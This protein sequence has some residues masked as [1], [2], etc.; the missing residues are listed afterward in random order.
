MHE[1]CYYQ[2]AS[3][4]DLDSDG[5]LDTTSR[6]Y[7]GY[8]S[9]PLPMDDSS[10]QTPILAHRLCDYSDEYYTSSVVGP[11]YRSRIRAVQAGSKG[12]NASFW[13]VSLGIS[14][15]NHSLSVLSGPFGPHHVVHFPSTTSTGLWSLEDPRFVLHRSHSHCHLYD[16]QEPGTPGV[17]LPGVRELVN[18]TSHDPQSIVVFDPHIGLVAV[19]EVA[20]ERRDLPRVRVLSYI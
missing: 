12:E 20:D 9:I 17:T 4:W 19:Q 15:D 6:S 13:S 8:F 7:F 2:T 18:G 14:T 1:A 16:Y 3:F 11:I 10:T 5:R